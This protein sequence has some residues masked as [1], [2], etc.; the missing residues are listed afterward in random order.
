M[1]SICID[2]VLMIPTTTDTTVD[3]LRTQWRLWRVEIRLRLLSPPSLS[4]LHLS[5][6]SPSLLYVTISPPSLYL[7]SVSLIHLFC[8]S[9]FLFK[10]V[11]R[12]LFPSF[13]EPGE[14][15]KK[16]MSFSSFFSSVLLLFRSKFFETRSACAVGSLLPF[17][18]D[19]IRSLSRLQK[20][21]IQLN[22]LN[23]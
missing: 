3:L 6:C 21:E 5:L 19:R 2:K 20:E 10:A 14:E 16:E 4:V 12:E 13:C 22:A 9:I 15:G 23:S 11:S 1:S 18:L 8:V 17:A 7:F